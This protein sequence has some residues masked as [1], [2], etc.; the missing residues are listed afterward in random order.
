M[1]ARRVLIIR[2]VVSWRR[3]AEASTRREV[4]VNFM[5]SLVIT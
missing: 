4:P 1:G 3:M 5:A 2:F